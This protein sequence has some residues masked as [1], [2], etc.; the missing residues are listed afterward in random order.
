[1]VL[2]CYLVCCFTLTAV[3]QSPQTKHPKVALLGLYKTSIGK[4][5]GHSLTLM[6]WTDQPYLIE[7][8]APG[9]SCCRIELH[10]EHKAFTAS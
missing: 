4:Q 3:I 1:M 5:R 10:M 9:K 2:Y 8:I 6:G 7:I